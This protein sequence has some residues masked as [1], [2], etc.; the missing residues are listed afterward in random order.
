MSFIVTSDT[1]YQGDTDT[2][3]VGGNQRNYCRDNAAMF[4][5]VDVSDVSPEAETNG[6]TVAFT[7]QVDCDDNE[8]TPNDPVTGEG[9]SGLIDDEKEND[10]P[11][12]K[13]AVAVTYSSA[14]P[15]TP[16][17]KCHRVADLG[18]T[19][20]SFRSRFILITL[21]CLVDAP[22]GKRHGSDSPILLTC[23]TDMHDYWNAIIDSPPADDQ[24]A[25][26]T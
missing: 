3:C 1:D 23:L 22:G 26:E 20:V 13:T 9:S 21:P 11:M 15:Q 8:G 17:S 14:K 25:Q 4:S 12:M 6:D 5:P 19:L 2:Q 24:L 7:L 18:I 10:S 16:S